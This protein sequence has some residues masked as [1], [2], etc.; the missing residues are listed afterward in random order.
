MVVGHYLFVLTNLPILQMLYFCRGAK[1][2][3]C[4]WWRI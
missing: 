4:K 3:S 1:R 2:F